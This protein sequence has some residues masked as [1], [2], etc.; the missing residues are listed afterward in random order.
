MI[1]L[2]SLDN[3]FIIAIDLIIKTFLKVYL[4]ILIFIF[5]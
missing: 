1:I 4:I 2:T 5:N 3:K